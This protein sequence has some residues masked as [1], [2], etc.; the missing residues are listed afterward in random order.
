MYSVN[1]VLTL[2][3]RLLALCFRFLQ[4]R[5]VLWTRLPTT[6][7]LLGTLADLG[8]NRSEL[9]VENAFLR[10]QLIILR[11][12]VKRPV[13]TGSDRLLFILLAQA[14]FI[15]QPE[16]LLRWHRELFRLFWKRRTKAHMTSSRVSA[17]TVAL[18][19]DMAR[20]N[21]RLLS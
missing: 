13:Y 12:Q 6:S 7:L 4:H 11:R 18:I 2:I 17:E 16:T 5:L 3:K 19:K 14:L 21:R 10:Q 9:L 1:C 15:I 8:R 20:N